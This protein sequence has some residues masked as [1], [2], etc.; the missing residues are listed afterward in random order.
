MSTE[1][2]KALVRRFFGFIGSRNL[3]AALDLVTPDYVDH[4]LP[5]EMGMGIESTRKYYDMWFESFPDAKMTIDDIL[6]EGDEVVIRGTFRG[7]NTGSMMGMPATGK[8]ASLA[9]I[10]IFCITD[11][12]IYEHWS[13]MDTESLMHQLGLRQLPEVQRE[14]RD[15][16][17]RR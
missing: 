16:K 11:G 7:T 2:N 10:D 1:Q 6:G 5:P 14:P 17:N 9:Y 13:E 8:S 12:M 4:Q 15:V 3:D